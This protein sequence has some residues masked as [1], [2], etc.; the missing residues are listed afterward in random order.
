M[1]TLV[2]VATYQRLTGDT[3]TASPTVEEKLADAQ[4]LVE[5][6]L[7]RP[8]ERDERTE[9]LRLYRDGSGWAVYPKATPIDADA[10]TG[11]TTSG[12]ALTGISP[13]DGPWIVG[14]Y[15][16]GGYATVTYTGGWTAE[17]LP[18]TIAREISRTAKAL[19]TPAAAGVLA[20]ASSIRVGDLSVG[21]S[22]DGAAANAGAGGLDSLSRNTLR[23]YVRRRAS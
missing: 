3:S 1:T 21:F 16:P 18:L 4:Q 6:Y 15:E 12:A 13:D 11:Y 10:T 8:L 5:E 19:L 22:A 14:S 7:R 20:G 17:T 9:R 2:P 23:P